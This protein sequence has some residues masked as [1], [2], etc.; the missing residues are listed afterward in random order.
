ML[1]PGFRALPFRGEVP[2]EIDGRV[3]LFAAAAA[4][5]VGG[6][7][8]FRAARRACASATRKPCFATATAAPPS[9]ANVARRSLVAVEVALA[10]V[11]LCGAGLLVKSLAGL[12]QVSP[13]SIRAR[14]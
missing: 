5:A 7:L 10:I 13:G 4:L 9:V 1:T 6:D 14:C 3:L 2:I 11:V 12:L 8:W